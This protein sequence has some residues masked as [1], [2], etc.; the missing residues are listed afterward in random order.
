VEKIYVSPLTRAIE[1]ALVTV[2]SLLVSDL[3][4]PLQA[5]YVDPGIRERRNFMGID[6]SGTN[7]DGD[8]IKVK[9]KTGLE[10]YGETLDANVVFDWT[11]L[12]VKWWQ[13][14]KEEEEALNIRIFDFLMKVRYSEHKRILFV[15][16]SHYFKEILTKYLKDSS[17]YHTSGTTHNI[18]NCGLALA[19]LDF[20]KG[21][22]ITHLE[23]LS[24]D[25][26][27]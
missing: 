13:N 24:G 17:R 4:V 14:A 11:L 23:L 7:Y 18:E 5:L 12:G 15:G 9:V 22:I 6:S 2:G 27:G 26:E 25:F 16:H 19:D 1:T 3:G 21:K 20:S 8:E 10:K